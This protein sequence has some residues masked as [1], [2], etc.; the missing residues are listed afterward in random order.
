MVRHWKSNAT[1]L[2]F[3]AQVRSHFYFHTQK[4]KLIDTCKSK[5][6]ILLNFNKK[7]TRQDHTN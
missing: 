7:K 6:N 5:L 4:K 3:F 2:R 1:G